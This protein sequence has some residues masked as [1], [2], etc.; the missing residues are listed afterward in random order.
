MFQK[1]KKSQS[2]HKEKLQDNEGIEE[3]QIGG[4]YPAHIGEIF[5]NRYILVKK[6]GYGNFS[7]VWLAKDIKHDIFVAIKIIKS[8]KQY[9]EQALDEL[10]LFQAINLESQSEQWQKQIQEYQSKFGQNV[11]NDNYCVKMLNFFLHKSYLGD[12]YC[13]VFE[14]LGQNFLQLL[15]KQNFKGFS[16][17][18][19]IDVTRQIL[20][21]LEFLHKFAQII[22]T[23]LK[24]DNILIQLTQEQQQNQ[25]IQNETSY[26][27]IH[28]KI[29][30]LGNSCWINHHFSS[31]I[32]T[33]SYRAPEIILGLQY[34]QSTDIWSLGCIF[35]EFLTGVL[36]FQP[37]QGPGFDIDDDH[38]A[39]GVQSFKEKP[40]NSNSSQQEFYSYFTRCMIIKKKQ[41]KKKN[42]WESK[43]SKSKQ[44]SG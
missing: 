40:K 16:L 38:L 31:Y 1:I 23:D 9:K 18:F 5:F 7:T 28:I 4:Y 13:F 37:Q 10:E 20:I 14:L 11:Y 3:Y 17:N 15:Q 6:I 19:V 42:I 21:G 29:A 25:Q 43:L 41:T 12:N 8:E 22:H 24:P 34:I 27:Q 30:D 36:L 44:V 2:A 39:Q 32:Q 26:Q 33:R 35:Y